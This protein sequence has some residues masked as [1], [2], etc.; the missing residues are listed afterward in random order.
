[1]GL[2]D[3]G[4]DSEALQGRTLNALSKEGISPLREP[5]GKVDASWVEFCLLPAERP[6]PRSL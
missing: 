4:L 5:H 3:R 1:M 2:P 6:V